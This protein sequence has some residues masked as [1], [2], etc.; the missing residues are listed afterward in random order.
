MFLAS[1]LDG[2]ECAISKSDYLTSISSEKGP[3]RW[4][5]AIAAVAIAVVLR[6]AS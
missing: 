5:L 4:F 3:A 2:R 1:V 6:M